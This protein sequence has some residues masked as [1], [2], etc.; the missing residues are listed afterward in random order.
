MKT[1]RAP[2]N[3][4]KVCAVNINGSI[5]K[6]FITTT[7]LADH[8]AQLHGSAWRNYIRFKPATSLPPVKSSLPRATSSPQQP[9]TPPPTPQP[10]PQSPPTPP[11]KQHTTVILP[12][13]RAVAVEV[14]DND[15]FT[16]QKV[17][18]DGDC[19]FTAMSNIRQVDA[20]T[21]R[22]D[23]AH[24]IANLTDKQA[25]TIA[26]SHGMTVRQLHQ[27]NSKVLTE[28]RWGEAVH[29]AVY[30]TS[31]NLAIQIINTDTKEMYTIF[32]VTTKG[33]VDTHA[34]RADKILAFNGTDHYD[35]IA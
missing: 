22:L 1:R 16:V 29:V 9:A 3:P 34:A 20:V 11:E 15:N 23:I 31:I 10:L 12:A 28:S 24:C 13:V 32:P 5:T 26:G 30:A 27:E 2:K 25:T 33:V 14:V 17:R 21:V 18:G 4:L 6:T 8:I 35:M 7:Q 19:M